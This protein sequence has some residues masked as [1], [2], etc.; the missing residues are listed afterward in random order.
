M[1]CGME[2]MQ[3]WHQRARDEAFE[4]LKRQHLQG[5]GMR[6]VFLL[7][8]SESMAGEGFRQMKRSFLDIINEIADHR[9]EDENVAVLCFGQEVKFLHYLSNDYE[10]IRKCIDRIE[11]R[12][13]SPME[14]AFL[15]ST[16]CFLNIS[17]LLHVKDIVP[18]ARTILITDGRPTDPININKPEPALVSE[19]PFSMFITRLRATVTTSAMLGPVLFIPVGSDPNKNLLEFISNEA[20]GV[21]VV[22]HRAVQ[23][24]GRFSKNM[25]ITSQLLRYKSPKE[26]TAADIKSAVFQHSSYVTDRDIEDILETLGNQNV[27][28]SKTMSDIVTD[29]NNIDEMFTERY[30]DMPSIGTRVKRGPDWK[31][32]NQDSMGPGTVVGHST[33]GWLF[34]EWDSG[35]TCNYRYGNDGQIAKYDLIECDEPRIL[36]YHQQIATGCLVSSG[37]DW[38]WDDQD[39]GEENIGTVYRVQQEVIYVKWP[40]GVRS[41]YRFGYQNKFDV[42][43]RDPLNPSVIERLCFQ[44]STEF[45]NSIPCEQ[46][47]NESSQASMSNTIEGHETAIPENVRRQWQWRDPVGRWNNYSDEINEKIEACYRRNRDSTVVIQFKGHIHRIILQQRKHVDTITKLTTDI[48]VCTGN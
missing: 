17:S 24:V 32:G 28:S 9:E 8:S 46:N 13:S 43:I 33:V 10:S 5:K 16:S 11:C 34:V 1:Q 44:R 38:K 31:W 6:T 2:E 22:H 48:R 21:T 14:A 37:P 36:L 19:N 12:G 27:S 26:I 7:D 23:Q 41:N 35:R 30:S 40:H 39:G 20:K 47:Q 42:R 18:T 15:L 4:L 3:Y 45:K 25:S 29:M